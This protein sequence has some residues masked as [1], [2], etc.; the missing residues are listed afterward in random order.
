MDPH[1]RVHLRGDVL[2][3]ADGPMLRHGLQGLHG[4]TIQ[5]PRRS[6]QQPNRGFLAKRFQRFLAA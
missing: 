6:D 1:Y 3:E 2:E 5:V 4:V